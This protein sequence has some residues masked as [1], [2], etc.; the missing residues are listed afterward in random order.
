MKFLKAVFWVAGVVAAGGALLV[1]SGQLHFH[2][3]GHG[4]GLFLLKGE[5]GGYQLADDLYLGEEE[6]LLAEVD[7]SIL[8]K[9][10]RLK[11]KSG[12]EAAVD[13]EWNAQDG[14]GVIHNYLGGRREL[15]IH[16]S[17]Y[18]DSDRHYPHGLFIGGGVASELIERG[19]SQRNSSGMAYFNGEE[20]RHIWCNTNEGIGST[21]SRASAGPSDWTFLGSRVL[22]RDAAGV[23]LASDHRLVLDGVPLTIEREV[24]VAAGEP[25]VQLTIHITN[26]GERPSHF[27][28]YYGDEP[29]LGDFGSSAGDVGWLADRPV[30][31]EERVD[32][33][34]YNVVGM[35]DAGNIVIGEGPGRIPVA[36]FIEWR[37]DSRPDIVFFANRYYGYTHAD[38][39]RVPLLGNARSVGLYWQSRVLEPG[40]TQT[41]E[42]VIGMADYDPARGLPQ[43]PYP[44]RHAA[45]S[46]GQPVADA[47]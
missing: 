4:E 37:D 35:M 47:G 16:F 44:R 8:Q 36:N 2:L 46:G 41:I 22:R 38:E 6:R 5:K 25:F 11:T 17:R 10:R 28:Y 21:V 20:W 42:L 39:V 14:E 40:A 31:Y 45:L 33:T 43:R 12:G 23:R 3:T 13:L 30:Y 1:G 18:E 15:R 24:N 9:L 32:P 19:D 27:F 7:L 34:R 29:W 26:Q